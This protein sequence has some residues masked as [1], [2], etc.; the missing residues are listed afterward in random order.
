MTHKRRPPAHKPAE[1]ERIAD[2][3]LAVLEREEDR[4][5]PRA[6][7]QRRER[8]GWRGEGVVGNYHTD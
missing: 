1:Q 5:E 2:G 7:P 8:Y 3:D 6:G 4:D